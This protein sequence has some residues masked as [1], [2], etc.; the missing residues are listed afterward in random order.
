MDVDRL[1]A[2]IKA[3]EGCRLTPYKDTRGV[4]T[5]G[6][7]HN[8]QAHMGPAMLREFLASKFPISQQQAD[9][10][11]QRDIQEATGS[12]R[13]LV[14]NFSSLSDPRQE[15]LLDMCFNLGS[16]GLAGFHVMLSAVEAGDF[17]RAAEELLNSDAA[18]ED[19]SRYKTLSTM[20]LEG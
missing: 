10:M 14:A 2:M 7:G 8:L 15:V 4:W 13:S 11:L 18:E 20:M 6:Y 9:D 17:K 16:H 1:T 3:Q 19:P 12:T 5:I